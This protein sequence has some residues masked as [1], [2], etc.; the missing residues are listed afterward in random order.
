M[1]INRGIKWE[2]GF[3]DEIQV[4]IK[5]QKG[6]TMAG[7]VKEAVRE[8]LDRINKSDFKASTTIMDKSGRK[9]AMVWHE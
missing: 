6:L 5:D 9:I 3:Y 1:S 7:F 4:H 8:K 2:E